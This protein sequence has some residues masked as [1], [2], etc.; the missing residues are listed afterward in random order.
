MFIKSGLS[1]LRTYISMGLLITKLIAAFLISLITHATLASVPT[2]MPSLAPSTLTPT[3]SSGVCFEIITGSENLGYVFEVKKFSNEVHTNASFTHIS[4]SSNQ[5]PKNYFFITKSES[6]EHFTPL[7][8]SYEAYTDKKLLH[9]KLSVFE[10][11]GETLKITVKDS[12]LKKP[13]ISE[14]PQGLVLSEQMSDLLF[15]RR[16]ITDI[17]LKEKLI[18]QTFSEIE[19]K[20]VQVTTELQPESDHLVLQHQ[21]EGQI[22]KTV[23]ASNGRLLSSHDLTK[24]I[25]L[26]PCSHAAVTSHLNSALSHKPF[27]ALFSS[28]DREKIKT[29]CQH[30]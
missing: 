22:F 24:N 18:F 8:S 20:P 15:A 10:A 3:T 12:K 6:D 17:Q 4:K 23:H 1:F 29:C 28:E 30:F 26:K 16:K 5:D 14:Q 19:T 9:S 11:L 21:F 25:K 13:V 2:D 7:N 27:Q